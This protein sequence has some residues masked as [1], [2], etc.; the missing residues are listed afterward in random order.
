MAPPLQYL[1]EAPDE[2][3]GAHNEEHVAGK[4]LEEGVQVVR[5][6]NGLVLH[7]E[8]PPLLLRNPLS[9]AA[10]AAAAVGRRGGMG[11]GGGG[12]GGDGSE[13]R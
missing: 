13:R 12:G 6:E 11:G 3:A 2:V 5:G 10:A 8:G 9:D 4:P 1:I 7:R